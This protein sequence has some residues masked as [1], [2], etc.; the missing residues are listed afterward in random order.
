MHRLANS[1]F[2]LTSL[3]ALPALAQDKGVQVK[4]LNPP[5]ATYSWA[6]AL[7]NKGTVI[8]GSFTDSTGK[9]S[10]YALVREQYKVIDAPGSHNF[11]RASGVNNAN[12]IVGDYIDSAGL[13]HGFLLNN[14]KFIR[15]DVNGIPTT[16]YA[17]NDKGNFSGNTV[18]VQQSSTGFVN[19]H[20]K[21]TLFTIDNDSTFVFG[22]NN[23]NAVVGFYLVPPAF[24]A[25]G[26]MRA[27]DGTVTRIDY[28]GAPITSCLGINDDG[29]VVGLYVDQN[30]VG[31][32]FTYKDGKYQESSLPDIAAINDSGNYVGSYTTVHSKNLGYLARKLH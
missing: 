19:I 9:L 15:Y 17:I 10:G 20:G 14:G 2:L 13:N 23:A 22:I 30:D 27:E 3:A 28:P 25:H 4:L 18:P 5:G 31:H 7:N 11:T 16:V 12:T 24:L 6:A 8:V 32:G 26:Y 29:L 21:A 1:L